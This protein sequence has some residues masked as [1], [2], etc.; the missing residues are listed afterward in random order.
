MTQPKRAPAGATLAFILVAAS[1]IATS[2]FAQ[3]ADPTDAGKAV[4]KRANCIGC[5]KWHGNGGGGYGNGGGVVRE[6]EVGPLWNQRDAE[7][8]CRQKA[9]E[10]RGDWTGQ[11]R[12]TVQ[13]RMSV[14]EIRLR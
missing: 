1:A 11:W 14:C 5:H 2:A 8:K 13:G 12:T 7:M 9:V 3:S 6:F 10:L 4:F